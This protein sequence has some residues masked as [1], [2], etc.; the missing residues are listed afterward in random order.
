MFVFKGYLVITLAQE[1]RGEFMAE[2]Y[3][4]SS[5]T[6]LSRIVTVSTVI[7]LRRDFRLS[8]DFAISPFSQLRTSLFIRLLRAVAN[9]TPPAST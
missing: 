9:G 1:R 4:R 8:L 7:N 3:F 5:A 2:H 6:C